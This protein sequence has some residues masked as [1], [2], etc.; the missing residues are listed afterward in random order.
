MSPP[1]PSLQILILDDEPL[2]LRLLAG[3]IRR[4]GATPH[5]CATVPEAL[6][7]F[8]T[9]S[10]PIDVALL[11]LTIANGQSGAELARQLKELHLALPIILMSGC[12][13][14]E[15]GSFAADAHLPKPFDTRQLRQTLNQLGLL[16]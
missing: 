12:D 1:H 13:P 16:H 2:I 6:E 8:R 15:L 9:S 3:I 11:D 14:G 5:P 7:A 10:P 4:L